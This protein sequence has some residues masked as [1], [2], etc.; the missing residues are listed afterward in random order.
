MSNR[1]RHFHSINRQSVLLVDLTKVTPLLAPVVG[2]AGGAA[3]PGLECVPR[4]M[5]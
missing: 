4:M 5:W 1:N 2:E 3:L